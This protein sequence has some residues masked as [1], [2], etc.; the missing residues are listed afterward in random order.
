MY[1]KW[2][3]SNTI[4]KILLK[5]RSQ[6]EFFCLDKLTHCAPNVNKEK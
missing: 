2:M 6:L 4:T 5:I 3:K 1:I